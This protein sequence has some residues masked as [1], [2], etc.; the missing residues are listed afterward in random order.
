MTTW[1]LPKPVIKASKSVS[2]KFTTDARAL[3]LVNKTLFSQTITST[4][5][6]TLYILLNN[7][8]K[9]VKPSRKKLQNQPFKTKTKSSNSKASWAGTTS[10]SF[11]SRPRRTRRWSANSG[12]PS[13]TSSASSCWL[14]SPTRC[15]A[16]NSRIS[17][18]T[19]WRRAVRTSVSTISARSPWSGCG[20]CR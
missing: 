14:S 19:R 5:L 8:T 7:R 6:L 15:S 3:W 13:S 18:A 10:R 17:S 11:S 9:G 12:Q 4:S 20:P 16:T 2:S 1:A